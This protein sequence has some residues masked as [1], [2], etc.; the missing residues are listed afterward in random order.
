MPRRE[1]SMSQHPLID[2]RSVVRTKQHVGI[3]LTGCGDQVLKF[4][5][6]TSDG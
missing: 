3:A 2:L 5:A 6:P 4:T 1:I